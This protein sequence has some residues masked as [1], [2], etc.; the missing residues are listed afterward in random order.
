[1]HGIEKAL[2]N[3]SIN[4]ILAAYYALMR[5]D[6]NEALRPVL[7]YG[8]GDTGG[9][10]AMPEITIGERLRRFDPSAMFITEETGTRERIS[11]K[12][13]DD[14]EQF[15]TIFISDP[16]DRSDQLRTLLERFKGT[17]KKVGEVMHDR[18]IRQEW[19]SSNGSPASITGASSALSCVYHGKVIFSVMVNYLTEELL[20]ACNAGIYRMHLPPISTTMT[21]EH[22]MAKGTRL[23]FK[24]IDADDPI[25]MRRFVTFVGKS[26]YGENLVDSKLMATEEEY[27]RS[28]HYEL[29]GGPLRVLYLSPLQPKDQPIGFILANG[30]KIG[31]WI[32]WIPY[33]RFARQKEDQAEPVL[34][35]FEVFQARPHTKGGVLMSTPTAYSI[36]KARGEQGAMIVDVNRFQNYENP[37]M[38]RETLIATSCT[39]DW[40]MRVVNQYGY[41][42]IKFD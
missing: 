42:E 35:L 19:E 38:I 1:M 28:L 40:A 6:V 3:A 15:K 2:C 25:A 18:E 37:S 17:P 22:I 31:E 14:P 5:A 21:L 16:T 29:P 11:I 4:A 7:K 36:F 34:R 26:V 39:N 12:L 32:H 33:I 9:Y 41:R 30:E 13:T 27:K 8:K 10:D 23:W 24:T 20:V